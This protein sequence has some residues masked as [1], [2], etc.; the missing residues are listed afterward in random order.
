MSSET[1]ANGG[2]E[3]PPLSPEAVAAR[4]K[5]RD[6]VKQLEE[7]E[8]ARRLEEVKSEQPPD[9]RRLVTLDKLVTVQE[10]LIRFVNLKKVS[11]IILMQ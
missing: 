9:Q 10:D 1:T 5:L 2:E 6:M 7:E 3:L 8:R 4:D 11:F